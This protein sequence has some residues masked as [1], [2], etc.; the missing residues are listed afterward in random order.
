MERVARRE[1]I[2]CVVC[3]KPVWELG[4]V[5]EDKISVLLRS[6]P[7]IFGKSTPFE[8]TT[9]YDLRRFGL[10]RHD[11]GLAQSIQKFL[12]AVKITF[13]FRCHFIEHRWQRN[14]K[15]NAILGASLFRKILDEGI[16]LACQPRLSVPP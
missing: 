15:H 14:S 6:L 3:W 2:L 11:H 9:A 5:I 7:S 8:Q 13:V 4:A 12:K 10:S 16:Q 1:C